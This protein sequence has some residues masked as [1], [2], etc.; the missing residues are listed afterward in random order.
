MADGMREKTTNVGGVIKRIWYAMT[1]TTQGAELASLDNTGKFKC[2][3]EQISGLAG[4]GSRMVV[5]DA[6]GNLSATDRF[7]VNGIPLINA[8]AG[9]NANLMST[10]DISFHWVGDTIL[11]ITMKGS[12]GVL[13]GVNLTLS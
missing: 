3:S 2:V 5:A 10:Y 1:E 13:R 7:K 6:S 12:D 4:T 8:S 9:P 11:R